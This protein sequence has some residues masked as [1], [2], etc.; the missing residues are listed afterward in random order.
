MGAW[1]E[2]LQSAQARKNLAVAPYMGAWIET[3]LTIQTEKASEVAPYMGAWIETTSVR[4]LS[5]W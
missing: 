5:G 2:T 1:I 3:R 4:V